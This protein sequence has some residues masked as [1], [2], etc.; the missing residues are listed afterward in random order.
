[1]PFDE[2]ILSRAVEA[3][4]KAREVVFSAGGICLLL[5]GASLIWAHRPVRHDRLL[6]G[7]SCRVPITELEPAGGG[8]QGSVIVLHGLS[9]NRR[10]MLTLGQG[11]AAAGMRVFLLDSPGHGNS[12]E[13]FTLT[14]AEDC[15]AEAVGA[16]ARDGEIALD[17]TV[18][19]GHS[20]GGALALRLADRFPTAATIAISPAPMVQA[21]WLPRNDV[22]LQPPRH[23]PINML[24]V[25]GGME[26][27]FLHAADE[28]LVRAAGGER[29]QPDDFVQ[30]RAVKLMS[31]WGD[32]HTSLVLDRRVMRAGAAWARE[33]LYLRS[34]ESVNLGFPDLGAALGLAGL[35]LVF[36]LSATLLT[37]A[38][39]AA[40]TAS[41][42]STGA[43]AASS[44]LR[45]SAVSILTAL[46]LQGW[47]PLRLVHIFTGDYYASFKLLAGIGLLVLAWRAKKLGTMGG[48]N[49][50]LVAACLGLLIILAV[51]GW[52]NLQ[53]AD[54]WLTPAR[55]WR[56]LVL[57]PLGVPFY[58][59]EELALGPP[60]AIS[61]AARFTLFIALR[62]VTWLVLVLALLV[63]SN[64][65]ILIL[66]MGMFLAVLALAQRMGA[67]AVRRR[68]G[69][70]AAAALFSAI[71]GAW[72][73]AGVFP[74]T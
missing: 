7:A 22:L 19:V 59:A 70:A 72:F 68:T 5:V 14:R 1:V 41:Q 16:L 30:R 9:S 58:L 54:L 33:A 55:W 10:V 3:P 65:Q 32:G 43:G 73:I 23:M 51:G 42:A 31:M 11:F 24:I 25:A 48:A 18:L 52:L 66:L 56:F 49:A 4:M 38:F 61:R 13:P 74:L 15:A 37:Q 53:I 39:G 44:L 29:T 69:S 50:L 17:R 34:Q 26:P 27:G 71:L 47:V 2:Q 63:F 8:A 46:I 20:M 36:P 35:L 12:S 40:K 28:A 60:G 45:W 67:D 64:Q 21:G 57:V 62:L 6:A